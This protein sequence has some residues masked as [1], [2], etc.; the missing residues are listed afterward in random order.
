MATFRSLLK[1]Y[2]TEFLHNGHYAG[3]MA[4]N[5][6]DITLESQSDRYAG[7]WWPGPWFNIMMLSLRRS[8]DRLITTMRFP[9]LLPMLLLYIESTP[10]T[11][12]ASATNM[13]TPVGLHISWVSQ[14]NAPLYSTTYP[15]PLFP[16]RSLRS[17]IN[18]D[19]H[20]WWN[21]P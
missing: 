12:L 9:I 2:H 13:M 11:Y 14:N 16:C 8:W 19:S 4:R 18:H 15:R 17:V 6:I 1:Q 7:W 10:G 20:C 21:Y 5:M 3:S